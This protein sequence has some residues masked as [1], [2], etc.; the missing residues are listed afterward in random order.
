MFQG[1][2]EA[3]GPAERTFRVVTCGDAAVGKSSLVT[4]IVSGQFSS[5]LPSTLGNSAIRLVMIRL[6]G[7]T[8]T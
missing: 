7:S 5:Q 6:K 4:R 3:T 8:S 1:Y 2:H